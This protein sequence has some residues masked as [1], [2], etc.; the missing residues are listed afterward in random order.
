MSIPISAWIKEDDTAR[1]VPFS[2]PPGLSTF[3]V[4]Y[5]VNDG[6][7]TPAAM[8]TPTVTEVD[9]SNMPGA[10]TVDIDE[11]AM[12]S[13]GNANNFETVILHISA[14]GWN[15]TLVSY[16]IYNENP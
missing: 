1:S 15:G 7:G 6:T 5:V 10:Y 8:T 9:S 2:A 12:V 11:A 4:Y 3:T 14:T 13:R 16:V